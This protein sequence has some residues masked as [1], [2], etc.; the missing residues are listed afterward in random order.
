MRTKPSL[1]FS[2]WRLAPT[3]QPRQLRPTC[4]FRS[5]QLEGKNH[6]GGPGARVRRPG[7][8]VRRVWLQRR[9]VSPCGEEQQ[10]SR[11]EVVPMLHMPM[12]KS[13][14][15]NRQVYA[16]EWRLLSDWHS[17]QEWRLHLPSLLAGDEA[18]QAEVRGCVPLQRHHDD[19]G[20]HEVAPVVLG[21][22]G[23]PRRARHPGP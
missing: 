6:H 3:L 15:E 1:P 18:R 22:L 12:G 5:A 20:T 10:S 14:G 11:H 17:L 21:A 16:P 7:A 2:A 9:K 13:S 8:R 19:A 4:P 23:K